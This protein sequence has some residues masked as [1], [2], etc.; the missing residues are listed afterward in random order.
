MS[1]AKTESALYL[2][3]LGDVDRFLDQ[4]SDVKELALDTEGAS[5]HRF[6]DRIYLLQISTR[7]RSAIID[8][9]PI[10]SPAKL[11]QLLQSND[12]EVVFHD[13]D[14]DLRLLHQDYGWHVTNIFDTRIAS[15]LLGIKSFG[16]AALLEQFFDVRLDKKHQRADWSMRPLTPDMLEYAA[17]DTRYLLRL[18][19]HMTSELQRRGRLRWAE[20]EFARLEGTR[21][22]A[23]EEM[24]GFLRLKGARDLSRR[25]LAVLREVA[26]W[27][28]TVAAQLDRATFRV[29]SNEVL[30]ELARRAP[31]SVSELS[32]IKGMP[33]GMVERAGAD[34]TAAIRRGMEAPEAELPKFPRG[35]RLSKDRDFDDRVTRLKSVRD[36][37]ATRLELDPGV[38]CSRERLENVARSGAKRIEDLAAVPD[39]RRWQIEEMG[40][41]FIRALQQK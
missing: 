31:R 19:D 22:E 32:A 17:Q 18:K 1:P 15:Q 9:L 5:F 30:L 26:N 16:L 4:I 41:G 11:G 20:E 7:E 27:R 13:A 33:K 28:D 36:A 39:L 34:I 24:E 14:Y 21:W 10:G 38:L 2:D 6:L 37:A 35:Q 3:R 12:V 23:E 40:E 29:M 25:E 8:P